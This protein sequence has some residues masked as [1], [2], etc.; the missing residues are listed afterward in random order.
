[1]P[2]RSNRLRRR[3]PRLLP[4][5]RVLVICEGTKTEPS[6]FAALR[7]EEEVR[8]VDV[9]IEDS[10]GVPKTLVER[11]AELK[12]SAAE[13]ARRSD[14]NSIAYDEVWCVFDVDEH[15]RMTEALQQA[16]DNDIR[17]AL[18]NPCFELWILLHFADQTAHIE[19]HTAQRACRNYLK[20]FKKQVSYA[21]LRN[22]YGDAVRRATALDVMQERNGQ[23]GANPTTWVYKLTER[24]RS[25]SRETHLREV[26]R[27]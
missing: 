6:Y 23:P 24:L 11:A 26:S 9:V 8:L 20:G 19:R 22:H 7:T 16:R 10:G 25:L 4:R 21:E 2:I 13:R 18:S 27:R 3:A 5:P 1:M 15:P 12:R 14:D 17:V